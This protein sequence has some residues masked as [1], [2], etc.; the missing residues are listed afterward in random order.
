MFQGLFFEM[1]LLTNPETVW[2]LNMYSNMTGW[3]SSVKN[4]SH[5]RW[6]LLDI[7]VKLKEVSSSKR[8]PLTIPHWH[9]HCMWFSFS[10]L[11]QNLRYGASNIGIG[12]L[13]SSC[14]AHI[15]K[16]SSY[17]LFNPSILPL[18]TVLWRYCNLVKTTPAGRDL[19]SYLSSNA[20]E[21]PCGIDFHA[22]LLC[23]LRQCHLASPDVPFIYFLSKK[24][25][26]RIDIHVKT[27]EMKSLWKLWWPP[28]ALGIIIN[29]VLM[30]MFGTALEI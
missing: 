2:S 30:I 16:I 12:D 27:V 28:W 3:D 11:E 23:I 4:S 24:C 7:L 19:W 29:I 15:W 17:L 21:N 13:N 14:E 5:D 22:Y 10:P 1:S 9:L 18:L 25:L 6:H 26:Q 20:W 8:I